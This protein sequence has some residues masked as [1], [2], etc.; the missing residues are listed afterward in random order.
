MAP[1]RKA[2]SLEVPLRL[3]EKEA[4]RKKLMLESSGTDRLRNADKVSV[5][6]KSAICPYYCCQHPI[7]HLLRPTRSDKANE[8][9]KEDFLGKQRGALYATWDHQKRN[10]LSFVG[11]IVLAHNQ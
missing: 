7:M 10:K 5:T 4:S 11:S 3:G 6:K 1:G 9:T 2:N 8:A